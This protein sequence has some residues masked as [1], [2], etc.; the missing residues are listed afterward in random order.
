MF[1]QWKNA[2]YSQ[3]ETGKEKEGEKESKSLTTSEI[4]GSQR[5]SFQIYKIK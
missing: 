5:M 2:N 1:S 3:N 4:S